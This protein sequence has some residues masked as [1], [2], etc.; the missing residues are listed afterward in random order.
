MKEN[1]LT[2]VVIVKAKEGFR[3]FIDPAVKW[4]AFML[5]VAIYE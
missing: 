2:L 1:K 5:G 4:R 3:Y